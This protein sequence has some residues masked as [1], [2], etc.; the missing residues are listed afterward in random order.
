MIDRKQLNQ[1]RKLNHLPV[2]RKARRFLEEMKETPSDLMVHSLQLLMLLIE[3]GK[4][5]PIKDVEEAIPALW[6]A[7]P[8]GLEKLLSLK[9]VEESD[10]PVKLA[11]SL[12]ENLD[13]NL[14]EARN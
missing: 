11:M 2:N 9:Q 5:N 6:S 4:V 3:Q 7:S 12:L 13:K 8:T 10:S 14:I 1:T